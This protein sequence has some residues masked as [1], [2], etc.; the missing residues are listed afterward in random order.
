MTRR[1]HYPQSNSQAERAVDTVKFKHVTRRPHYPQ[2]NSQAER[3]VETVK[4]KHVTRRPHYPQSYSQAERAV[5]TVKSLMKKD[6][7][8]RLALLLYR[9]TP[10]KCGSARQSCLCL[11]H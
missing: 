1:P 6:G 2:S 8:P 10:L 5:E 4:F 11:G 7:D 9:S 3:A